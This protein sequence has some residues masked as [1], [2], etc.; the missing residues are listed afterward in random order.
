MIE[1]SL[2]DTHQNFHQNLDFLSHTKNVRHDKPILKKYNRHNE[3]IS[4]Y[5]L[6]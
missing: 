2:P 3:C 6:S 1:K 4:R 5:I